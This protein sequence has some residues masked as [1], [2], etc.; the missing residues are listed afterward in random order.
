[1]FMPFEVQG[2]LLT[3]NSY[4]M[5]AKPLVKYYKYMLQDLFALLLQSGIAWDFVSTVAF[6]L[7]LTPHLA[8]KI[9][10]V[11]RISADVPIMST[12]T[13]APAYVS[14]G[15]NIA[16]YMRNKYFQICLK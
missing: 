12:M 15:F 7:V 9:W 16:V 4:S 10:Y 13:T 8:T 6:Y 2:C 14:K 5:L 1:M 3:H 11:K